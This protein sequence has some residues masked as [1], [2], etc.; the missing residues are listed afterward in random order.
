VPLDVDGDGDLDIVGANVGSNNL[1][2]YLN[3]GSGHFG[4]PTFFEAG[5]N[6]E[7]GLAAAD[8]NGDGITDV[9]VGGRNGEQI[10]TMLR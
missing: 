4:M 10:V 3:D 6:G 9:V 7:Y 8:M 2:L 1:A 5:V